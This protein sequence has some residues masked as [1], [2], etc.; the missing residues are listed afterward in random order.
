VENNNNEFGSS[1]LPWLLP[2]RSLDLKHNV[3]AHWKVFLHVGM[4]VNFI[5]AVHS[6][7]MREYWVT[8]KQTPMVYPY[9]DWSLIVPLQMIEFYCI[10]KAVKPDLSAGLFWRAGTVVML[11]FDYL[12]ERNI[13]NQMIEFY[14]IL[15][16]VKPEFGAGSS[17]SELNNHSQI[18]TYDLPT[19]KPCRH[20]YVWVHSCLH[21]LLQNNYH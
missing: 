4:L 5:V 2:L 11:V 14:C 8:I 21:L 3:G 18:V 7:H 9:I 15:E 20:L 16:A 17:S 10:L 19:V 6:L 13:V 12:G 1:P